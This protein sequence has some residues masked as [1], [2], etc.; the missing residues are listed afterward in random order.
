MAGQL[1]EDSWS[2]WE[3]SVYG[4][5]FEYVHGHED[6]TPEHVSDLV[7]Y[8]EG[9]IEDG[10]RPLPDDVRAYS[11]ELLTEN[12]RALTDGGER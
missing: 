2:H 3:E 8:L 4:A 6:G 11:E 7:D 12:G 5:E 1:S 9:E 10:S